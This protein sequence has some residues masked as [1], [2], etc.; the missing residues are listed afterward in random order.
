MTSNTGCTS[1]GDLAMTLRI[2]AVA[3]CRSSA[4]ASSR[5]KRA[6]SMLAV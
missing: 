2:S 1:V 6:F 3:A 5:R 4:I